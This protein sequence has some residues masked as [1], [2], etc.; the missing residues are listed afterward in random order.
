ME[1]RRITAA[2]APRELTNARL[3]NALRELI[4]NPREDDPELSLS[5]SDG[6]FEL[7]L[8]EE[9]AL[10]RVAQSA[11]WN[12]RE[13]SGASRA[14]IRLS[15]SPGQVQLEIED[16]GHGFRTDHG[17]EPG[18][19][20]GLRTMK[21]RMESVGGTLVVTS[22]DRGTRVSALIGK[23]GLR[24]HGTGEAGVGRPAIGKNG[25]GRNW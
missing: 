4:S 25:R 16:N 1:A 17:F 23:N 10:L 2:L 18:R 7:S 8:A 14:A 21:A 5:V 12:V 15:E 22:S 3:P 9:A 20:V 24:E 19:G 13:H 11:L 6:A